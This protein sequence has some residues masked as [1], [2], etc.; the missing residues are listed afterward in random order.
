MSPYPPLNKMPGASKKA[1][2]R[3][4]QTATSTIAPIQRAPNP[5]A[6]ARK[7]VIRES[8]APSD[9]NRPVLPECSQESSHKEGLEHE[10]DRLWLLPTPEYPPLVPRPGETS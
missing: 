4:S 7:V 8:E 2:R 6:N 5:L 9:A 1:S 10:L 3:P